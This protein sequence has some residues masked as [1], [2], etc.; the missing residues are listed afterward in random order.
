MVL[1][2]EVF[3]CCV[4]VEEPPQIS[5]C[6]SRCKSPRPSGALHPRL[7]QQFVRRFDL[8]LPFLRSGSL[9]L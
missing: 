7:D 4:I 1:F 9:Y 6:L 2:P 3:P 8:P 5:A